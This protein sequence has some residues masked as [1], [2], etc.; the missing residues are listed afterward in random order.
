MAKKKA[1]SAETAPK[2]D[3]AVKAKKK[4]EPDAAEDAEAADGA[5]V[6]NEKETKE[7]EELLND[8]STNDKYIR[9]MADFQNF[10]RRSAKEKAE[11]YAYASEPLATQVLEVMDNFERALTQGEGSETPFGEGMK[12]IFKQLQD[13]LEKNGVHEIEALGEEFN[14][15]FHNAVMMEDS[16]EYESGHITAVLQKGYSLNGKVIRPSMV[17]VA[18]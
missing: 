18:N 12:L 9:L 14:P 16:D 13:A 6:Q 17:K 15:N 4:N 11:I 5:E 3:E 10:K 1:E 8:E 2:Q 7:A